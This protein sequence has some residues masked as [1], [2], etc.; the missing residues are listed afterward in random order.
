L[1][2][3]KQWS[4]YPLSFFVQVCAMRMPSAMLEQQLGPILEGIL[5]WAEDSKNKFKLKVSQW[6]HNNATL[7]V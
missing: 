5:L 6:V 1:I 7:Y 2:S 4:A 3:V